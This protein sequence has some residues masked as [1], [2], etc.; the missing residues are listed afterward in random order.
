MEEI[1][2]IKLLSN[3][4]SPPDFA[5]LSQVRNQTGYGESDGIRTADGI[6]MSLWPSAGMDLIG[7]EIKVSR[8]DFISELKNPEKSNVIAKFCD[9]W[10]IVA[11]KEMIKTEELP[12]NWGLIEPYG[13]GLKIKR[14]VKNLKPEPIT[15]GFLASIFRSL[16]TGVVLKSEVQA[17]VA[18]KVKEK[19]REKQWKADNRVRECKRNEETV[20]RFEKLVGRKISSFWG[21][22]V[23]EYA[24]ALQIVVSGRSREYR[25][26]LEIMMKKAQDI[27]KEIEKKLAR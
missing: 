8:S 4:Y 21:D 14:S 1:D 11:P 5:F 20:K 10:Y 23:E 19:I 7:F 22:K 3:K 12:S 13:S 16:T 9:H 6:A 15:K 18:G 27:A 24:T 17:I 25:T 26:D 2:F